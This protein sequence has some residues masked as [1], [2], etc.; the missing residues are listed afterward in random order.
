MDDKLRKAVEER[1]Y[2]LWEQ[3]GRPE[4]S[5]LAYWFQAEGE[6]IGLSVAGEEDP[7]VAVDDFPPGEAMSAGDAAGEEAALQANVDQTVPA[8]EQLPSGEAENP[9]S[10]RIKKT[11]AKSRPRAKR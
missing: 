11:P 6:L 3:A 5:E 1:A 10:K 4:G 7:L 9:I 8:A 2:A